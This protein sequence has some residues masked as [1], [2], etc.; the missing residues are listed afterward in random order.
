MKKVLSTVSLSVLEHGPK[1]NNLR[2]TDMS[3]QKS[4]WVYE[5]ISLAKP[6]FINL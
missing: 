1:Q 6:L 5:F 3:K 4:L 2:K